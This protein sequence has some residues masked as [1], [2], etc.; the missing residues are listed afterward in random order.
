MAALRAL[1]AVLLAAGPALACYPDPSMLVCWDMQEGRGT[2]VKD[3]NGGPSVGTLNGA[4][5]WVPAPKP[6]ALYFTN[7]SGSNTFVDTGNWM[8]SF[9]G[10]SG[11]DVT[12]AATPRYNFQGKP[13]SVGIT[14]QLA[15][16]RAGVQTEVVAA[17]QTGQGWAILFDSLD[18][19]IY[20][21]LGVATMDFLYTVPDTNPHRLL[22]V[23]NAARDIFLFIDGKIV[24]TSFAA[25]TDMINISDN[26]LDVGGTSVIAGAY[27]G[28]ANGLVIYGRDFANVS[29]MSAFAKNEYLYWQ[30]MDGGDS[31][32]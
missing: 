1:L 19:V 32:E 15:A 30:G 20:Y 18:K 14:F 16:I 12:S 5:V 31:S 22:F 3:S 4:T 2:K 23:R 27:A 6:R 25:T 21:I 26:T 17:A 28:K 11:A 9:P 8:V 29:Q 13:F 10:S 24:P 7:S